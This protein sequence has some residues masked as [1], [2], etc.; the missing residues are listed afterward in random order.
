VLLQELTDLTG[1]L[2]NTTL[3]INESILFQNQQ[4]TDI[5]IFSQ[6]NQK[7]IEDQKKK[8][9]ER[10]K[11]MARSLWTDIA[12]LAWVAMVFVLAYVVIRLFPKPS[13]NYFCKASS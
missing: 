4:L 2:K 11:G 7:E 12:T 9:T 10:T 6:E 8:M 5:T 3:E 1:I 13:S